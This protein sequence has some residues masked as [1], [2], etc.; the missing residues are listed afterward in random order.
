MI[1]F[2]N[3]FFHIYYS[4]SAL[5]IG[6][7]EVIVISWV[8]GIDRFLEDLKI[9]LGDY[10][11]HRAYWRFIW[12]FACPGL[13]VVR[14]IMIIIQKNSNNNE[15][16]KFILQFI[17][18]FSFIDI[19]PPSYGDYVYPWWASVIGWLLSLVSVTAIPFVAFMK[20]SQAKGPIIHVR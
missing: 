7:V 2:I 13:I 10:P 20:I 5:I 18:I 3:T 6:L 1:I 9:M 4:F 8:Y 17:L 15:I 16:Q 12:K 19:K 11:F 14:N